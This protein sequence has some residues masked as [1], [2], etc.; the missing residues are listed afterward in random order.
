MEPIGTVQ[1]LKTR[2]Y[3]LD[4]QMSNDPLATTVVVAPS[5]Y[6]LYQDGLS[7]FWMMTGRI[8]ARAFQRH[9][10]GLFTLH[11]ADEP[12]GPE[13][14]FPSRT[15]GPD[16]WESFI[17]EPACTEGHP[18]QRLRVRLYRTASRG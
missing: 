15:F 7:R 1:I 3:A 11:E 4:A 5:E 9:G 8:T 6:T 2:V 14:T 16:E 13:V 10:D 17:G 12:A 18:E